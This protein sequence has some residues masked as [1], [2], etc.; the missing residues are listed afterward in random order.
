M[1][2]G[3]AFALVLGCSAECDH[4][5][6][7]GPMCVLLQGISATPILETSYKGWSRVTLESSP[8]LSPSAELRREV[9]RALS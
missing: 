5:L 2:V 7:P 8:W 9:A 3:P 4:G 1:R 6:P